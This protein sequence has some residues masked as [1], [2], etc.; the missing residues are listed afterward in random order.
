MKIPSRVTPAD[1]AHRW[2]VRPL[3]VRRIL[4]SL[5]GTLKRQDRGPRWCLS[6]AEVARVTVE[7]KRREWC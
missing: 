1:P 2:R 6:P 3:Q 4:R 5:F 7:K